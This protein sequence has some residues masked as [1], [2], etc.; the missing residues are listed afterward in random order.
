MTPDSGIYTIA[1]L[2]VRRY[3]RIWR[4][5]TMEASIMLLSIIGLIGATHHGHPQ[6]YLSCWC[7]ERFNVLYWNLSLVMYS[8]KCGALLCMF[9]DLYS[10][11]DAAYSAYLPIRVKSLGLAVSNS[12]WILP[13]WTQVLAQKKLDAFFQ[14]FF[15]ECCAS[16]YMATLGHSSVS[17]RR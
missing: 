8:E 6:T 14:F 2:W 3:P 17:R 1:M 12:R 5:T 7:I 4:H 13:H 11:T 15:L 10:Y 16:R 9:R